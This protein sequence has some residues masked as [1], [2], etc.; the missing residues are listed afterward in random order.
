MTRD[1]SQ[2]TIRNLSET[3]REVI[4]G[5][6]SYPIVLRNQDGEL[7]RIADPERPQQLPTY[8]MWDNTLTKAGQE[9]VQGAMVELY[10]NIG[11]DLNKICV[12]GNWFS[13]KAVDA[14]KKLNPYE[15]IQWLL[16]DSYNSNRG[17]IDAGRLLRR[18]YDDPYQKSHPH[19]EVIFT[20]H[21]LYCYNTSFVIG[22]A[23]PDIGT[24]IS[25]SRFMGIQES[26]LRHEI[27]KTEIFHEVG[28]VFGLPTKRRGVHNLEQSLGLH[29]KTDSCSMKQGLYVPTDWI[30]IT[31][32]RVSRG[33]N[34]YCSDCLNDLNRKVSKG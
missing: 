32:K 33:G 9:V 31:K 20:A 4:Y 11:F 23:Q 24:I 30:D 26:A 3:K 28:H 34:P 8:I 2:I 21:D 27:I 13:N 18:L 12:Y 15:S 7:A 19:W 29:C 10:K 16:N 6:E 5:S 14:N 25:L 17:Q 1:E 22:A